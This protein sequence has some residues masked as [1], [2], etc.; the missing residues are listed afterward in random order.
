MPY[1][2]PA[3]LPEDDACRPLFIP[4]NTEWLALFGG[5]LTELTKTWNWEDSGGLTVDETVSKMMEIINDWYS[6]TCVDCETPG[7]YRIIRIGTDGHLEEIGD[8]GEWTPTTGDYVIPSPDA[9]EG[10]SPDDQ[11]CLAAKNAVN[12]LQ[13]LYENWTTSWDEELSLDEAITAAIEFIVT[14]LGF[15]FAPIA[16]AIAAFLL[17]VFIAFYAAMEYLT[18]DLWDENFSKQITCFLQDCATNT[19][20]VVTFDWD[21]V[22]NHLNSLADSFELTE[23]QIRLYLQVMY[24]LYFIGGVDGLNLAAATTEITNDDCSFC[25]E[26]WCCRQD[27]EATD[28]G[29]TVNPSIPIGDWTMGTGWHDASNP[30]GGRLLEL[31]IEFDPPVFIRNIAWDIDVHSNTNGNGFVQVNGSTVTGSTWSGEFNGL[32][33]HGTDINDS[34][35]TLLIAVGNGG[36]TVGTGGT[37]EIPFIQIAGS[38]E[39]MVDPCDECV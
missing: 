6:E 39:P 13:L 32:F 35:D 34:V 17:P 22:V 8:D 19:D 25:I 11:I 7:G 4:D 30:G 37:F 29:W 12:V 27:F 23:T 21:C 3:E 33:H 31:Y 28:A 2:T 36:S 16:W 5:A 38:G 14:A 15:A 1:L 18:A 10:G 20:G 9:R 26:D 24:L